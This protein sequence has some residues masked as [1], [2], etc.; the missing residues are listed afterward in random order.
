MVEVSEQTG[1]P[2]LKP[3]VARGL[4]V[5]DIDADGDLDVL[6]TTNGGPAYLLRNEGPTGRVV[7]LDLT[8]KAPN[9]DAI[10]AK[11][12]AQVGEQEQVFMVRTGSSYLSHSP[13]SLTVG[14]GAAEQIDRLEIRWPDGTVEALE[15]IAAGARYDIAQG[16]GIVGKRA[17]V[18]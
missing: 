16:E 2:F 5:G 15:Q 17:F 14:L 7:E 4:S 12:T 18:Q 3:V 11:V 13:M 8:G 6:L 10:G 1:G 9:R